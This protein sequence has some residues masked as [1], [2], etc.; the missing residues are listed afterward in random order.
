MIILLIG[1]VLGGAS[2]YL[3]ARAVAMPRMRTAETIAQ[4][5]AYG[6]S[7]TRAEP[8]DG[9]VMKGALDDIAGVIGGLVGKR[10]GGSREVALRNRLMAAGLYGTAPRKFLG[11]QTLASA[12]HCSSPPSASRAHL[13][14]SFALRSRNRTWA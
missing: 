6:Y 12:G 5:D 11:Y 3:V 4:I 14:T 1:L 2:V 10:F 8:R 7:R 9:S 13:E